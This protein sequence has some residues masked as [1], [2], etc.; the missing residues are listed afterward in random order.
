M[1]LF[2]AAAVAAGLLSAAPAF[3]SAELA[4]AKN[5]LACHAVDKKLVGPSYKDVAAKYA[6]QADA[7]AK[8]ATKV[9]K[10]GVGAWGQIPMPPNPQVNDADAKALVA[11][12]LSQK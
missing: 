10:G 5:C 3:A 1:K 4:K 6:G 8:L 11:W 12:I 9:Q 7:A 2:V